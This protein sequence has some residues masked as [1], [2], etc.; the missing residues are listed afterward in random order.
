[1]NTTKKKK[2]NPRIYF[3][4]NARKMTEIKHI[5]DNDLGSRMVTETTRCLINL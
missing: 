4:T 1:M 2:N 3:W 5:W